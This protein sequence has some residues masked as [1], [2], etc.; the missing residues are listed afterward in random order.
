MKKL[1]LFVFILVLSQCQ[2]GP[3]EVQA[4]KIVK[5]ISGLNDL[6]SWTETAD[7]GITYRIFAY[8]NGAGSAS[9]QVINVTKEKL[10]IEKLKLEIQKLKTGKPAF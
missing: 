8:G 10:E 1:I 4:Q 7:D 2:I 3:R 5:S 6:V 9:I